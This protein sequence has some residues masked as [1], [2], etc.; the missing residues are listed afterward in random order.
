MNI[1]ISG[2]VLDFSTNDWA[3]FE[4]SFA[5]DGGTY[6]A[7]GCDSQ[8]INAQVTDFTTTL[9]PAPTDFYANITRTPYPCNGP[10]YGEMVS[11]PV[12]LQSYGELFSPGSRLTGYFGTMQIES[13]S[14]TASTPVSATPEPSSFIL[15]AFGLLIWKL[16]K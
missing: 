6:T 13:A 3:P 11:A 8:W 14:W 15:F 2:V 7:A 16:S 1:S 12:T 5:V 9:G 4:M 10:V